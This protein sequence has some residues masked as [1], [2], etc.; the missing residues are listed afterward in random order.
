MQPLN[1]A[2]AAQRV[3]F[4]HLVCFLE[5]ARLSSIV[6][7][8]EVLRI[9]QPAVSKT[10]H[11][12]E[13]TLEVQLFDR[14]HRNVVL[15]RFGEVFLQYAGASITALRQ[16]VDSIAQAR[17]S[18]AVTVIVG[19]LPTASSRIM[20]GAVSLFTQESLLSKV[21]IVTGPNAFLMSQL[22]AGQVDFVIGRMAEPEVMKGFSFEQLYSEKVALVVRC[23]H[24]LLASS[25]FD[26]NMVAQYPILMPP[27]GSAI[28]PVVDRFLVA[29]GI[30]NIRD[31][32]ESVSTSF[33]RAYTR[34]TDAIWIISEGVVAEDLETGD[35][36]LLPLDMSQTL[37]PVGLTKRS[38]IALS[39]PAELLVRCV[40]EV[41]ARS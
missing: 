23:S 29:Q 37:G 10:L 11:E 30:G 40:R 32:V 31:Q 1:L 41:S 5:V 28:R 12:L 16:G 35:L 39:L 2:S 3:K 17:G 19:A 7:A 13:E 24:P 21:R 38:D 36:A 14:S 33:G 26:F 22:H 4:R 27:P 18:A 9:S 34:A 6:K 20:P 25:V 15:T 8:A